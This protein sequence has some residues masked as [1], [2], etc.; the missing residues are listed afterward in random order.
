M[1][2]DTVSGLRSFYEEFARFLVSPNATFEFPTKTNGS[3]APYEKLLSGLRVKK[4]GTKSQM[5][6]TDSWIEL[7]GCSAELEQFKDRLLV[8]QDGDHN[9]WYC[10]PV[11]LIIEADDDWPEGDESGSSPDIVDTSTVVV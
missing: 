10:S 4:A 8:E 9:H 7:E 1:L 11:S 6:I 2:L 3:P 5:C